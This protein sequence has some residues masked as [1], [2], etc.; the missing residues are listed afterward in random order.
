MTRPRSW[1]STP[2]A[3]S[4]RASLMSRRPV[5][6]P[7]GLAP[8]RQSLMPLYCAGLCDAVNIAP[9]A[10]SCRTRST[11]GRSTRARGRPRRRPG[12]RTPSAN[13]RDSSTP[14]GRMSRATHDPRRRR[15]RSTAKPGE[16]GAD[17][18]GTS[19]ASSWSGTT[20]RT[21]Y[22]LKIA[23]KAAIGRSRRPDRHRSSGSSGDRSR[24]GEAA[25]RRLDVVDALPGPPPDPDEVA[26]EPQTVAHDCTVD[27]SEFSTATG[28]SRATAGSA[29]RG[30]T[31]RRR[32]RS[33]RSGPT[34]KISRATSDR[35]AF[36]PHCVSR[37]WP[38]SNGVVA[39]LTTPA[40]DLAQRHRRARPWSASVWRRL[41][42][43]TSQPASTSLEQAERAA[44]GAYG[45][46][47][48]VNAT[49]RPGGEHP[50]AHRGAL[51]P[52]RRLARSPRSAPAARAASAVSSP[53]PS[54][55]T[56]ISRPPSRDD[57]ASSSRSRS[58][59]ARCAAPR[60]AGTTTERRTC[61]ARPATR[62]ARPARGA[63][64]GG[65]RAVRR[66]AHGAATATATTFATST[67]PAVGV[68]RDAAARRGRRRRRRRT[69]IEN[70]SRGASSARTDRRGT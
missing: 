61:R 69:T 50:G 54:S 26:E 23:S 14:D 45:E 34:E 8:D 9:G 66:D 17:G 3:P 68:D 30:G 63:R 15:R 59:V 40:A 20:P 65:A 44:P 56:T 35:N 38:S 55:T 53:M 5:S 43:T 21:S 60:Y 27:R 4:R 48:S 58:T 42:T 37:Y 13:A 39:T 57:D 62:R 51:A 7:M 19:A 70:S 32:T 6:S 67:R 49:V 64:R 18:A 36:S 41:P 22:A 2:A 1:P 29:R 25:T 46:S 52:V 16:R 47:A 11:A 12:D 10:S 31:P 33:R 28:T 24:R